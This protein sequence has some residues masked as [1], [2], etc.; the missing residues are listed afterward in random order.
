MYSSEKDEEKT[1]VVSRALDLAHKLLTDNDAKAR[2]N[3]RTRSYL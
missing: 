1:E 2:A 3:Y